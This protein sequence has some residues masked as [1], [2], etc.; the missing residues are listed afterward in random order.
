MT[1]R[2]KRGKT[3]RTDIELRAAGSDTARP[4]PDPEPND[5]DGPPPGDLVS[6]FD[7]RELGGRDRDRDD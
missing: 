1:V 2:R 7:D 4:Q 6:Y 3:D 5:S